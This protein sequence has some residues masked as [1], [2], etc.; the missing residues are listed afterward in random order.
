MRCIVCYLH[1]LWATATATNRCRRI[2]TYGRRGCGK[3]GVHKSDHARIY[4]T[5]TPPDLL[6][7]ETNLKRGEA[8][9]QTTAF[10]VEPSRPTDFL[11][12]RSRINLGKIYTIEHNVKVRSLGYVVEL[13]GLKQLH[14]LIWHRGSM[15]S[16]RM[17]YLPA[18]TGYGAPSL[19]GGPPNGATPLTL[20]QR[21]ANQLW[22]RGFQQPGPSGTSQQ[23]DEEQNEEQDEEQDG[24]DNGDDDGDSEGGS[25]E[26]SDSDSNNDR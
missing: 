15:P 2:L 21:Q 7:A 22:Q 10:R 1:R 19:P 24:E 12:P 11:D 4:T 23:R 5:P 20:A 26:A 18:Q 14:H 16:I 13:E 25:D 6:N 17:P 9:V 3:N 8:P